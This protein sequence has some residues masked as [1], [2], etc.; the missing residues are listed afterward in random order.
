M[1]YSL[2]TLPIKTCLAIIDTG[3]VQL[4]NPKE[5]NLE[6]LAE[7]W[8]G[9]YAKYLDLDKGSFKTLKIHIQIDAILLKRKAILM[10]CECL[11]FDWDDELYKTLVSYG[12]RINNSTYMQSI[13]RIE[14]ESKSLI[15]KANMLK[16]KLPKKNE[17]GTEP[18]GDKES[19]DDILA[20][21]SLILGFD[22][23]Y[24]IISVT[25]FFALQKQVE[26]KTK[27]LEQQ[28]KKDKHNG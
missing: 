22:Y 23:D 24:N 16:A 26:A 8:E 19:I 3:N 12:Y 1:I 28:L 11:K 25:K 2:D 18:E 7:A 13:E 4:L 10:I 5:K 20:S 21:Y 15:L 14:R 27:S 17:D 9:L 6:K